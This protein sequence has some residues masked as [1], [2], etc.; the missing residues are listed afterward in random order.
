MNRLGRRIAACV[1][2]CV[3]A[4]ETPENHELYDVVVNYG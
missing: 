3:A 4:C 1:A 2:A